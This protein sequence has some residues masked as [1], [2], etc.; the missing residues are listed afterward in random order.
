MRGR[1]FIAGFVGAAAWPRVKVAAVLANIAEDFFDLGRCQE[2][3][4]VAIEETGIR[5]PNR[6]FAHHRDM[7]DPLVFR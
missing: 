5:R 7:L 4:G 3:H 6:Q 2:G 1:E